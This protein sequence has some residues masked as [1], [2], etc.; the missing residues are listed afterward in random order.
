[1]K[2]SVIPTRASCVVSALCVMYIRWR[3]VQAIKT[4]YEKGL[5]IN[6]FPCVVLFLSPCG[7]GVD[8]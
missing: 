6:M 8:C 4:M 5:K 7:F 3:Y 2:G 1:M